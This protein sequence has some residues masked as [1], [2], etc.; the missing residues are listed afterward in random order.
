MYSIRNIK[1]KSGLTATQVVRYVGHKTFVYKHIG[2]D[3]DDAEPDALRQR[4]MQ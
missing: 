2:S 1:T 4:A 3:R